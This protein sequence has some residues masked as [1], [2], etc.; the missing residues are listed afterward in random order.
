MN[1]DDD[2]DFAA[3]VA[4]LA[5]ARDE[6]FGRDEMI[7][8]PQLMCDL[9]DRVS[10]RHLARL[11]GRSINTTQVKMRAAYIIERRQRDLSK[12]DR[13][14][15]LENMFDLKSALAYVDKTVEEWKE[16]GMSE[17]ENLTPLER[18]IALCGG[19]QA[20]LARRAG[21]NHMTLYKARSRGR[22]SV[23]MAKAIADAVPEVAFNDLVLN[24]EF[25]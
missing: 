1:F 10:I 7:I 2:F 18:A 12:R 4:R 6:Y 20:E 8:S 17:S 23:A 16:K 3:V 11:I 15:A 19:S 14:S 25:K 13:H 5:E 24:H 21:L 22:L 9:A